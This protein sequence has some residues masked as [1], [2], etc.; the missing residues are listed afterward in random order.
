MGKGDFIIENA[1]KSP[2]MNFI[3][4]EKFSGVLIRAVQKVEQMDSQLDNLCLLRFDAVEILDVFDE[5]EISRVYLNFSDPWPK[6]R[7]AK[8]R[9]T[10]IKYLDKYRTVLTPE[11]V[12]RFKTDNNDLFDFSLEQMEASTFEITKMTRDL[13]HSEF[14]E[15]NIKTEYE[16]RF[17]AQGKKSI[18]RNQES[19]IIM[20]SVEW[21]G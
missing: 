18:C 16:K 11:A 9:L 1:M 19:E 8:R 13:H 5:S 6:D 12:V 15:G 4:I 17:M 7:W 21:M 20:L 3:G 14:E 10:F 2:D